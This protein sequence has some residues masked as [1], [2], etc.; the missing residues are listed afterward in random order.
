[1]KPALTLKEQ[2]EFQK[3]FEYVHKKE[4]KDKEKQPCYDA[5]RIYCKPANHTLGDS[6][7]MVSGVVVGVIVVRVI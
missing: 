7:G 2:E 3:L 4:T 5:A 1:M 6:C